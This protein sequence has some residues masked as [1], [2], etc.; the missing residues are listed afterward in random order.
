MPSI[1]ENLASYATDRKNIVTG[2]LLAHMT[3]IRN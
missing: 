2:N 3:L 1:N